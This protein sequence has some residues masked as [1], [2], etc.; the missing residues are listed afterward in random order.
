MTTPRTPTPSTEAT[1]AV[2]DA[3]AAI[4]AV[5]ELKRMFFDDVAAMDIAIAE[6]IPT[7]VVGLD[8]IQ[9]GALTSAAGFL[10]WRYPLNTSNPTSTLATADLCYLDGQWTVTGFNSGPIVAATVTALAVALGSSEGQTPDVE[11]R[12]LQVPALYTLL[13]W[14][15]A[16]SGDSFVPI[17]DPE[18]LLPATGPL[19]EATV[20]KTLAD[21]AAHYDPSKT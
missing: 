5:P 3:L 10:T 20:M 6:P 14:L 17:V 8:A 13:I 19:D 16:P 12:I 7:Y 15:H 18:K 1:R 9:A 11:P 21:I 2:R 4:E